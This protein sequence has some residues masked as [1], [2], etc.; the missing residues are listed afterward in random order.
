MFLQQARAIL[1]DVISPEPY[2]HFFGE[3]MER[4]PLALTGDPPPARSE[5][6]GADP[7][8]TLLGAFESHSA[9]L[10]CHTGKP[11]GPPPAARQVA[12]ASAFEALIREYHNRNYSVRFPDI[13]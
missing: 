5:I 8:Q 4:G 9:H 13:A 11:A 3:V 10:T 2:D 6:L 12:D 1:Q 7:K